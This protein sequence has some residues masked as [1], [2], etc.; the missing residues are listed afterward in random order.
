MHA[1]FREITT[2]AHRT[3]IL[4]MQSATF[5]CRHGER[6]LCHHGE[7]LLGRQATQRNMRITEFSLALLLKLSYL[8]KFVHGDP[9]T[10]VAIGGVIGGN[11]IL[12]L[13]GR[14]AWPQNL[15]LKF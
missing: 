14:G 10:V 9:V 8:T 5:L 6:F 2:H 11:D 12:I 3:M 1:Q 7:R 4:W 15:P 13:G